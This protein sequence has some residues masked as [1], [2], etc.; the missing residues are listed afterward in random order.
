VPS[1]RCDG[2]P[3]TPLELTPQCG[4]KIA[5]ILKAG[6]GWNVFPIDHSGAAQRQAV[7]WRINTSL[8]GFAQRSNTDIGKD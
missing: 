8:L 6:K 1:A 3:N 2:R 4:P 7:G 5:A